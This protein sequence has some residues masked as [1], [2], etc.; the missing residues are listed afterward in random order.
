AIDIARS[1]PVLID[2]VGSVGDQP[3]ATGKE[4][5]EVDRR[6]LVAFGKL[7]N[8]LAVDD[9]GRRGRHDQAAVRCARKRSNSPGNLVRIADIDRTDLDAEGGRGGL[10]DA[11]L[12]RTRRYGGVSE[13]RDAPY[14]GRDQLEQFEPFAADAV[15]EIHEAGDV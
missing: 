1:V 14:A 9:R 6:Q 3:A 11:V 5:S 2:D 8:Q 12:A 13:D 4:P 7:D 15:F 10:N